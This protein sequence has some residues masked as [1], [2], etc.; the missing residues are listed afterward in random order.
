MVKEEKEEELDER[1]N[2]EQI[3][4]EFEKATEETIRKTMKMNEENEQQFLASM[5][6]I[7]LLL[8]KDSDAEPKE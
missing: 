2:Q 4:I 5:K 1:L 7:S 3:E 6:P 8:K